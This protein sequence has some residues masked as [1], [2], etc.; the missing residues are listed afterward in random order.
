MERVDDLL[1]RLAFALQAIAGVAIVLMMVNITLD[2]LLK[3]LFQ[4][5]I[6]GTLE[7]VSTYYM[8]AVVFL[9]IGYIQY[10]RAHI[11]VDLFTRKMRPR[12]L[13]K[14]ELG[15]FAIS[16][17]YLAVLFWT[18]LDMAIHQ[19]AIGEAWFVVTFDLPV[20]PARWFAPLGCLAMTLVL[21]LQF[22]QDALFLHSG[23][24][25]REGAS[26]GRHQSYES[27]A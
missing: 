16:T 14:L 24:E 22:A 17:A 4:Q 10:R 27:G 18:T 13:A 19:T 6:Q 25:H 8:V 11:T 2:V 1:G 3:Y 9:P 23:R 15:V 26:E 20:W 21:I 12:S 7:V 5:P